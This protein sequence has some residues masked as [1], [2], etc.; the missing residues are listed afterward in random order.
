M[1]DRHTRELQGWHLSRS[2]KAKTAQD[3]LEQDVITSYSIHYTK[4]YDENIATGC[5]IVINQPAIKLL[6]E[7]MPDP[8]SLVMHDWWFYLVISAFGKVIYDP[9]PTIL[10]R[11]HGNNVEGMKSGLGKLKAKFRNI[12]RPPKYVKVSTQV[13]EFKR[14][15]YQMLSHEN[16]ML[17]DDFLLATSGFNIWKKLKLVLA[18][19]VY[20][21]TKTETL[22]FLVSLLLN[23]I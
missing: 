8:K 22:S 16:K 10:Y 15:F 4:L 3:A 14:C 9:E 18:G 11:Q 17:V 7:N 1:I 21:Q 13:A 23:R 2:S 5:T 12:T 19:K 20:R 6:R